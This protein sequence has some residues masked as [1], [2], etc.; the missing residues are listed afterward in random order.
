MIPRLLLPIALLVSVL[1]TSACSEMVP[2][3][4]V[5]VDR[6]ERAQKDQV[7]AAYQVVPVSASVLED[8]YHENNSGEDVELPA[9]LPSDIPSE[10]EI[11]PGDIIYVTVWDHPELTSP[12]TQT[13]SDPTVPAI[14]GRLVAADGSAYYPFVGVF[15]AKGRTAVELRAFLIDK[16][17]LVIKD[18][19]VDVRVV[20]FRSKRVEVTGEVTKPG[21]V[22]LDDTP[23]G[24][25]QAIAASGGLTVAA[26]RRRAV[27]TRQGRAHLIDLAG[28]VSGSRSVSNPLLQP[29]DV[30]HIPDQSGDEVFLL[31]A[32][33]KQQPFAIE[34]DSM[35]LIRALTEA[36]GLDVMRASQSGVLVF[37]MRRINGETHPVIYTLDMS[38]ANGML[39]ASQFQ[40][41]PRD[42]VYVQ[43][44]ALSQYNSVIQQILPTVTTIFDLVELKQLTK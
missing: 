28:L 35:P 8:L 29:G 36:G 38:H 32:V 24:V 13:S 20:A 42:V 34:Q 40:L 43:Q 33:V 7:G 21:T 26:S 15:Q 2:G 16:L 23:K 10:Y 17:K 22:T 4:N 31:G 9:V 37:R 12:Y 39:L 25:L 14:Q 11:G 3:L 27:L 5:R 44:G 19:Q 1:A 6:S 18:P 41:Q 30:L